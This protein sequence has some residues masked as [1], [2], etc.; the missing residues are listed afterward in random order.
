MRFERLQRAHEIEMRN[1]KTLAKDYA[2]TFFKTK[3]E[4]LSNIFTR[5]TL[6]VLDRYDRNRLKLVNREQ[7]IK[8]LTRQIHRQE[9]INGELR[10]Y[11]KDSMAKIFKKVGEHKTLIQKQMRL[12]AFNRELDMAE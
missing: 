4:D 11:I 9:R 3:A 8:A 6:I 10:T 2:V 7:R 5:E 1:I 12:K